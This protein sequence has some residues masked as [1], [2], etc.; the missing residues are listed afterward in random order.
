MPPNLEE[1]QEEARVVEK[2]KCGGLVVKFTDD[3]KFLEEC[4]NENPSVILR[5]LQAKL[6]MEAGLKV[7]LTAV[8]T[9]EWDDVHLHKD[10]SQALDNE[11][12]PNREKSYGFFA[13][14]R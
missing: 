10:A 2:K 9:T 11:F 4:I 7:C 6:E 12:P 8:G 1:L 14:P 3:H 13:Y 5:K